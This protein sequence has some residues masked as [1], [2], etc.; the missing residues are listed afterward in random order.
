MND[1]ELASTLKRLAKEGYTK[2]SVN[3]FKG[4][5]EMSADDLWSTTLDP[6]TRTL[7]QVALPEGQETLTYELFD[8]LMNKSNA[9]WRKEWMERRGNEVQIYDEG[10]V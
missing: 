6:N 5:G 4:L 1:E 7:K 8:N 9:S 2:W 3:R 10:E